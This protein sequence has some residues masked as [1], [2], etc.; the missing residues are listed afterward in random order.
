MSMSFTA[1]LTVVMR[2]LE[3]E[4]PEAYDTFTIGVTLGALP[5]P[6]AVRRKI[7]QAYKHKKSIGT[8]AGDLAE[9]I[10]QEHARR[11]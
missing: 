4:W 5:M 3:A 11:G 1:Y 8:A 10:T 6:V 9:F 2:Y 7:V